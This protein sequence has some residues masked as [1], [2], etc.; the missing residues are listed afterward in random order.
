MTLSWFQ[1]WSEC[2]EGGIYCNICSV[3]P[4]SQSQDC[5]ARSR[6]V[7]TG[8]Q[9]LWSDY[10]RILC[11]NPA[12]IV[13]IWGHC[14][15]RGQG[16]HCQEW[17]VWRT[18]WRLEWRGCHPSIFA[19]SAEEDRRTINLQV[20]AVYETNVSIQ[21]SAGWLLNTY[22]SDETAFH[23]CLQSALLHVQNDAIFLVNWLNNWNKLPYYCKIS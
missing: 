20:H 12:I 9:S 1:V 11:H 16:R 4:G 6:A 8:W 3:W 5:E 13:T 2:E 23:V 17:Q 15:Y 22:F 21:Q 19:S 7:A 10:M 14:C 18:F